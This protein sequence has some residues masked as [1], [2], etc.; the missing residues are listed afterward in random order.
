MFHFSKKQRLRNNKSIKEMFYHGEKLF[1]KPVLIVWREEVNVGVIPTRVLV[2]V[3]KKYIRHASKRNIIRRRMKEAYRQNKHHLESVL[4]EKKKQL[5]IGIIFQ[6]MKL[7]PFKL[8]EKKIILG[9]D[10]IKDKI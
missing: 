4:I 3:P 6:D 2:T 8:L 1:Y 10:T 5:N 9:L 7:T